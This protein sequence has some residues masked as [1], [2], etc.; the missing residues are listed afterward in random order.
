MNLD[1][2]RLLEIQK[3]KKLFQSLLDDAKTIT[4]WLTYQGKLDLLEKEEKDILK[5]CDVII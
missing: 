3:E 5:R 4:D 2:R 1:N